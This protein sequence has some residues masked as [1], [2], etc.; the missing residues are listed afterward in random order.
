MRDGLEPPGVAGAEGASAQPPPLTP[1]QRAL[2]EGAI[3]MVDRLAWALALRRFSG[4]R[5]ELRS[6]GYEA[7]VQAVRSYDA[8]L[9]ERFTTYAWRRAFG[10]MIDCAKQARPAGRS[11]VEAMNKGGFALAAT[12]RDDSDVF[13][14]ADGDV[15]LRLG[16]ACDDVAAGMAV[17][18]RSGGVP[19]GEEELLLREDYARAIRAL[20][21]VRAALSVEGR[22]L[23]ELRYEQGLTLGEI[24]GRV[25][26][27]EATVK[28]R[29]KELLGR[30]RR[31]LAGRGISS[32]PAAELP[33]PLED[34]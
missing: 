8:R 25:S 26:L 10:A 27:S 12:L 32:L 29:Y 13:V 3:P 24:A 21:E 17:A 16:D 22:L 11:L 23:L 15:E 19:S 31:A 9:G 7:L 30:L 33:L 34:A 20:E 6:A 2:V 14:D 5:D 18:L 1:R 4:M 28:R